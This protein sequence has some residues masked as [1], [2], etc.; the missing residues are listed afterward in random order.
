MAWP[1]GAG[2]LGLM[3]YRLWQFGH[4]LDPLAAITIDPFTPPMV[5]LNQIA[6]FA[7]YSYFSWGV[8]LPARR[9]PAGGP[10]GAGGSPSPARIDG[11]CSLTLDAAPAAPRLGGL[12]AALAIRR[13]H[14][15]RPPASSR[16][17]HRRALATA[18]PGDTIRLLRRHSRGAAGGTGAGSHHHRL[19]RTAVVDGDRR[20]TVITVTAD[21]VTLDGLHGARQRP[22][23]GPGRGRREA[24]P[25]HGLRGS[26]THR[27][28]PAARHLPAR[29]A[30]GHDRG[31]RHPRRAGPDR[32]RPRQRHP[33]LQLVA[34]TG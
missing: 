12:R 9:G 33:S 19:T 27:A 18:R 25:L 32:V 10:R 7:T 13:R 30:W 14:L 34:A 3:R 4:Q 26:R 2:G 28:G 15:S 11:P 24:G 31:Q 20:G 1:L 6:Q 5:G 29:V 22:V 17:P 8:F 23:D 21:S 16:T